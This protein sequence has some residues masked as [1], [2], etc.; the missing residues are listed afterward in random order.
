MIIIKIKGRKNYWRYTIKS[1][2]LEI[3][4]LL[5]YEYNDKVTIL[6]EDG[7]NELPQVYVNEIFVFEGVPREEGYL[8]ELVKK[9]LD[10]IIENK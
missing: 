6:E 8:L 1:W 4:D 3:K 10:K 2:C 5:E 9:V 7:D